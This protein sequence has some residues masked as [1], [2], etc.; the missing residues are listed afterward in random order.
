ML[1]ILWSMRAGKNGKLS[2]EAC[3][4]Y[5]HSHCS[6]G[7]SP[8]A[9]RIY[10]AS[11][12]RRPVCFGFFCLHVGFFFLLFTPHS[13]AVLVWESV[14]NWADEKVCLGIMGALMVIFS[15]QPK[16]RVKT[17]GN[18]LW[19][20]FHSLAAQQIA[21]IQGQDLLLSWRGN[22]KQRLHVGLIMCQNPENSPL[23]SLCSIELISPQQP[24][25]KLTVNLSTQRLSWSSANFSSA[26]LGIDFAAHTRRLPPR[27]DAITLTCAHV[28][29]IFLSNCYNRCLLLLQN[30]EGSAPPLSKNNKK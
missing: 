5:S 13:R 15:L 18:H 17:K 23:K 2:P 21:W 30:D 4:F 7:C 3:M 1:G 19:H 20:T 8:S 10:K 27:L 25:M 22:Y 14:E 11:L 29:V 6:S 26:S 24:C 9:G 12:E 16:Q 28:Y